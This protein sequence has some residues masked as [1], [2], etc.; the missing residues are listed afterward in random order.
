MKKLIPACLL[1]IV[2]SG[3]ANAQLSFTNKVSNLNDATMYSG[4][5]NA[6]QDVNGDKLD[7]IIVLDG[8]RNLKFEYQRLNGSWGALEVGNTS[9]A[10]AWSMVVGD[11]TNNGFGDVI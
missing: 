3:M 9:N 10:N 6:V 2:A 11:V 1:V 4:G 7:D 8:A 5:P